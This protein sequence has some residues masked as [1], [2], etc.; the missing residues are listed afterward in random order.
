M[1]CVAHTGWVGNAAGCGHQELRAAAQIYFSR[2]FSML[3]KQNEGRR[4]YGVA[5]FSSFRPS[6]VSL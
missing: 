3:V 5:W 1:R 2:P 4:R 6:G